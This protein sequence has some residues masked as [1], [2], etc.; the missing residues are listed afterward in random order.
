MQF[1]PLGERLVARLGELHVGPFRRCQEVSRHSANGPKSTLVTPMYG[2]A[3]RCKR[4]SSI[5]A[6]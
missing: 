2:P 1:G 5:P 6:R 4:L 3:A